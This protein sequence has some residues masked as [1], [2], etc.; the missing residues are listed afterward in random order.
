MISTAHLDDLVVPTTVS[1]IFTWLYALMLFTYIIGWALTRPMGALPPLIIVVTGL[2]AMVTSARMPLIWPAIYL[3]I[4]A[5]VYAVISYL[6]WL[7]P[8]WTIFYDR[9]VIPQQVSGA[10]ILPILLGANICFLREFMGLARETRILLCVTYALLATF[11][12]AWLLVQFPGSNV[13]QAIDMATLLQ[14]NVFFSSELI[15]ICILGYLIFKLP[16][17]PSMVLIAILIIA[18]TNAQPLLAFLLAIPC[19]LGLI[20]RQ[21][22]ALAVVLF[23]LV[24]LVSTQFVSQLNRLDV[25]SS[26]RAAFWGDAIKGFFQTYGL[27]V[28][29][30]TEVIRGTYVIGNE[31]RWVAREFEDG[32]M[33]V[34]VHNSF[35]QMLLRM[36][37]AGTIC[38]FQLLKSVFPHSKQQHGAPFEYWLFLLLIID[39]SVNV[40]LESFTFVFGAAML[41]AILITRIGNIRAAKRLIAPKSTPVPARARVAGGPRLDARAFDDGAA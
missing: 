10:L 11:L 9:A 20:R 36:G 13:E 34:G 40:T 29:Y 37:I 35:F 26:I 19:R 25:N 5:A 12:V 17:G 4:V 28:G 3:S 6:H 27:G 23:I 32:F 39:M 14:I 33:F 8:A 15:L 7:P 30:G 41:M 21:Q 38:V 24:A 18:S 2:A 22:A 31:E 16:V 1:R